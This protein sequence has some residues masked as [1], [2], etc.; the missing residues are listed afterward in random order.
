MTGSIDL[1]WQSATP[2]DFMVWASTNT[3][4]YAAPG[5]GC[6]FSND[7]TL[8]TDNSN[9]QTFSLTTP[10]FYTV[11]SE[12]SCGATAVNPGRIGIIDFTLEPGS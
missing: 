1:S 2:Y 3:P 6:Q 5:L 8:I 9:S 10:Q 4:Y 11:V 12:H 7:C